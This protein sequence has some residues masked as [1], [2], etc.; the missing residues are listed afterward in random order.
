MRH[1]SDPLSLVSLL[2]DVD[3]LRFVV[4]RLDSRTVGTE[5]STRAEISV[6]LA[7]AHERLAEVIIQRTA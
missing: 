5:E 6:K 4:E 2:K 3:G 1:I 7:Q